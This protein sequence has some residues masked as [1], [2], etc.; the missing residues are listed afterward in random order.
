VPEEL[1]DGAEIGTALEQ[2]GGEGVAQPMWVRQKPTK[3]RGVERAAADGEEECVSGAA[4]Q[5][6]PAG[7]Q[8]YPQP[9]RRFLAQGDGSLLAA[10]PAD[11]HCLLLEVDVGQGE[12]DRLLR[13]QTRGVDELHERAV[14][15]REGTVPIQRLDQRIRFLR[16]RR[17]R[18]PPA[19]AAGKRKL[20]YAGRPE[21]RAEERP[22][23]RELAR[24]RGLCQLPRRA[25]R[26]IGAELGRVLGEGA[27]VEGLELQAAP[28]K[29]RGELLE[30]GSIG[31]S[32][33]VRESLTGEKAFDGG[34]GVHDR[35]FRLATVL[36]SR[37]LSQAGR[38]HRLGAGRQRVGET[39]PE[40]DPL[41]RFVRAVVTG[42]AVR[43]G[44]IVGAATVAV[45]GVLVLLLGLIPGDA[46]Q[47][48]IGVRDP[49]EVDV[50]THA[51]ISRSFMVPWLFQSDFRAG[52]DFAFSFRAL[53][54]LAAFLLA[55][56]LVA[57]GLF[58]RR[59]VPPS[60]LHRFIALVVAALTAAIIVA[61]LA[62]T[63]GYSLAETVASAD[64]SFAPGTYFLAA[65][66]EVLLIG[67]F[68]FGLV[69]LLHTPLRTAV[70]T[71]GLLLGVVFL[72]GVV[73]FPFFVIAGNT[74]PEGIDRRISTDLSG[75]TYWS[76]GTASTALPLALGAKAHLNA[77]E[78]FSPFQKQS[79]TATYTYWPRLAGYTSS[80]E[81]ARL[82]GYVSAGGV[83]WKLTLILGTVALVLLW[84]V[85]TLW[86]VR[87]LGAPRSLDGLRQGALVG[88]AAFL[89]LVLVDWLAYLEVKGGGQ[90][91][92]W[93]MTSGGSLQAGGELIVITGL[94][95]LVYAALRPAQY[96]Y[97]PRRMG[98]PAWLAPAAGTRGWPAPET[99]TSPPNPDGE[100]PSFCANCGASFSRD[101]EFCVRCGAP[102][103]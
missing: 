78:F 55:G 42:A 4:R 3:R 90:V 51:R 98:V 10:L 6:R 17:M 87:A 22:D 58:V 5:A 28:P 103:G 30:I 12:V 49:T 43:S 40:R 60:W 79:D 85:A 19:P 100:R 54:P 56:T 64:I 39:Y 74:N 75:G 44:A 92:R 47:D 84:V 53:A 20:R 94:V 102:R 63:L 65:L 72:L 38:E 25:A 15:E 67:S 2:V 81:S 37:N 34:G 86:V 71:A 95:G 97:T 80:H 61:I 33:C 70:R 26:T 1:L 48:A 89:L 73:A 23:S 9:M 66:V 14:A 50:S 29:P 31:T 7:L 8:I 41:G 32:G 77:N 62:A 88:L 76:P 91:M 68:A 57:G 36:P 69:G 82:G 18:Q 93:G 83:G 24:Q 59:V 21:R 11:E 96:R 46:W 101:A 52:D 13:P 45:A 35:L 27:R 99:V 16:L